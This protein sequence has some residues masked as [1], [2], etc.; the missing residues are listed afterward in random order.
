MTANTRYHYTIAAW[1][2][3][4]ESWRQDII[5]R[6]ETQRDLRSELSEGRAL[7]QAA[8]DRAGTD[9]RT[10][11]YEQLARWSES[12]SQDDQLQLALQET[13]SHLVRRSEP[14]VA[15]TVYDRELIVIADRVRARY[16]AWYEMFPRSQGTIADRSGTFK[17][18]ERRLP[19][20]QAMG[21]DVLYLPPIHLSADPIGKARTIALK[22]ADPGS[23]Y[24]IGNEQGG[25]DAVEP[26]LGTLLIS[27]I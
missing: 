24:A 18:C 22:L 5:K 26:A 8:A 3:S 23:P 10:R 14:R 6:R 21:F 27:S 11:L 9:D 1:V 15:L 13:S 25:H 4:F 17:D 19:A 16:G 7:V 20:I 2:S 12:R